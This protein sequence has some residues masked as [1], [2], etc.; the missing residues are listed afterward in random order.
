MA[1]PLQE[2]VI[3]ALE[4]VDVPICGISAS[5]VSVHEGAFP[6]APSMEQSSRIQSA[7][8]WDRVSCET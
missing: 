7:V 2:F 3:L 4:D 5:S 6:S 8:R 1:F